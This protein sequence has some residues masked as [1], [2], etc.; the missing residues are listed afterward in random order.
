MR[1][2]RLLRRGRDLKMATKLHIGSGPSPIAGWVNIDILP[3]PGVDH[4]MDVR[5]GLPFDS[6]AFIF[7]EHFL[8]HLSLG[9]GLLFLREC[10][11][12][13]RPD[14]VLR[15]STPNLDWVWLTHYKDPAGMS[16]QQ[17]L[18][19]CLEMNRAFHGWGHR[20]LYN[21]GTLS[22][23]LKAAGFAEI[24]FTAYG[25][26]AQPELRGLERHERH[27]DVPFA[28]SVLVAEGTGVAPPDWQFELEIAPFVRDYS[29][30]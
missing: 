25:E 16:D 12:A 6:V 2:S 3:Y 10:R 24:T 8:E 27:A 7:A 5:H 20:F 23:A 13:L 9:D 17:R 30:M 15:L 14:G 26:S 21:S 19:G 11:R 22:R 29:A 4:I 18:L 28:P 1:F